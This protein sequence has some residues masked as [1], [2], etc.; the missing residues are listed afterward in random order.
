MT[1]IS[2]NLIKIFL[3]SFLIT[4]GVGV[5]SYKHSVAVAAQETG[6]EEKTD[7]EAT[8]ATT[9]SLKERI[10]KVVEEKES[11][12]GSVAGQID[13]KTRAIVGVVERVSESAITISNTSGSVIIPITPTVELI[14]DDKQLIIGDI[15]IENSVIALGLQTGE[16]FT[17]IKVIID[18]DQIMPRPQVVTIGAVKEI[19]NTNLSIESRLSTSTSTFSLNKNT[20]IIDAESN[21]ILASNLFEDVQVVIAGYIDSSGNEEKK[22]AQI[23]K[24]LVSL[25]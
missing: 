19:S 18:D 21:K 25:D 12:N 22:I 1:K 6:A 20:Q 10:E 2:N 7:Q 4:F 9:A 11:K 5:F 17:P 13:Y 23:V 14:K 8:S 3:V 24:A 16:T 15:E